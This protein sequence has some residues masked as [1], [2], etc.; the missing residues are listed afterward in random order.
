MKK[1]Q[2]CEW[3]Y[4]EGGPIVRYLMARESG[5][6]S[7]GDSAEILDD[8]LTSSR[9]LYWLDCL[10]GRTGF[11]DIHGSHDTCFENAL[12]KL[13]QYGLRRGV[14]V[15][16]RKCA[17]YLTWLERS[18]DQKKRSV[19]FVFQQAIV[20]AWLA[21]GGYLSEPAVRD[22][23]LE[24]LRVIDNF[25]KERDFSIYLDKSKCKNF[26]KALDKYPLIDPGLYIDGNFALPW[27]HDIFA[28][29]ALQTH[30]KDDVTSERIGHVIS[31]VLDRRYQQFHEGY[32][33][34]LTRK[35][36]YNVMGWDVLLPRY[37]GLHTSKARMGCVVQRAE[38]MS[39]F[40][41]A[42]SHG[43]FLENYDMLLGFESKS[44]RYLLPKHFV[45]EMKSK[46]F[47][48][49]GHMGLGENRRRITG[50]EVESTYWMMRILGNAK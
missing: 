44:G 23:V 13:T 37:D 22:F 8:L 14:G 6:S 11:K 45:G 3:L 26:P 47:V 42:R 38:L 43:W 41:A 49:G 25:V 17:P 19:L 46:Y 34:V 48:T 1:P 39:H 50:R 4:Q 2:L 33:L 15:F 9:V 18:I 36:R 35:N 32:G 20:A 24:R 21:V 29:R 31:Y 16:D 10:T 12:G 7:N 5:V 28:F 27:I 40:T 30:T